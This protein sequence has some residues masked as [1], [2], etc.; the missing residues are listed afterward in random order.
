MSKRLFLIGT[1]HTYQYGAAEAAS[2]N[3]SCSR[4]AEKAF[5]Q[6][7]AA[8]VKEH[9]IT[10]IAEELNMQAL[11]EVERTASVPQLM[12]ISLGL[13]HVYCEPDRHERVALG[14]EQENTI[15]VFAHLNRKS[16]EDVQVALMEQFL[17]RESVWRERI[18]KLDIWPVLFICGANHV[19]S[20]SSLIE[21][22][23]VSCEVIHSDWQTST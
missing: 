15:R 11:A 6:A 7:I 5:R 2:K 21:Q 20:F 18:E 12:A 9:S 3:A 4:E 8:A 17:K 10:S 1:S 14:I 23:G 22:S 16:E 13:P 19:S